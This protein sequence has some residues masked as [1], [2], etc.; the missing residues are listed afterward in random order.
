MSRY[1][2]V[3]AFLTAPAAAALLLSGCTA[4]AD[5][6]GDPSH[7]RVAYSWYPTCFDYAQSNPFAI[8]GR[9]VLDTLLSENP[10]TGELEPYL[11]QSWDTLDGGRAYEF[12]LR[13]GV[14]FS[15]GEALTAQVVADNFETLSSMAERGV[16]PTPG[17]YLTGFTGARALDDRTVRVDFDQPNAGFLQANT[18]GQL[19]IVAPQSLAASPEQR[20]AEGTIGSGPF[21]LDQAV[22]DE[23]VEYIKRDGYNWGPATFGRDG[24]AAIDRLTIRIVPEESVRAAGTIAG[25]YDIAYSITEN[26][27]AQAAGN[28][29]VTAVLAPNRGVVNTLVLNTAD[30]ILSDTAVRQA[31]Q[32]GID[33]EELVTTF[34][35]DDVE[36]ATDVVSSG[37]PYYTDH[38]ELVRYD[39]NL[40]RSILDAAG[41]IEG[42]DGVRTKDGRPLALTLTVSSSYNDDYIEYL[43][44]RLANIGI[45]LELNRVSDA[46]L[47]DLR[48]SGNWQ[49]VIYQGAARGD[50]D[51]IAAFYS[52]K[53]SVWGRH[54]AP[55]PDIDALLAG[56]SATIDADERHRIVN[57]AVTGILG[58]AYG[59]PLYDSA[60][61][62]LVRSNVHDVTFPVNSWEPIIYRVTKG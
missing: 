59:I 50:A 54:L 57:D 27:L 44:S 10:D 6:A 42:S 52:T 55:R 49:I 14:T 58:Q 16:S 60:Q 19:G 45:R 23:R 30:P 62:L 17:A 47:T 31:L 33:R 7:L 2:R 13:D 4:Q 43:Q 36:A 37:H 3:A 29:A 24:E 35:G 26:G 12:T 53:L 28:D 39:Q 61:M 15:N 32:H 51:G 56:Q 21:V 25:D 11:A 8:F 41:W 18:E 1:R 48:T 46:Q 38:G 5:E 20:C 9:Q 22:Q 40:S 34:F